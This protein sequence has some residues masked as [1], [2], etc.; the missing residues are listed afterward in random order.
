MLV[1][2]ASG[3]K[4]PNESDGS[5]CSSPPRTASTIER[6]PITS[7]IP[8]AIYGAATEIRAATVPAKSQPISGITACA[9]PKYNPTVIS[10]FPVT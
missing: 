1:A 4:V 5:A 7:R 3:N 2:T 9:T 8:N 10:C 6:T